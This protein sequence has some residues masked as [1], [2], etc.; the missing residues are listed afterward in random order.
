LNVVISVG[1]NDLRFIKID[2]S[3]TSTP[4]ATNLTAITQYTS[5]T[6]STL[7]RL[8]V[9]PM[10]KRSALIYYATS[11]STLKAQLVTLNI[12]NSLTIS[13]QYTI[14]TS[15]Y[16]NGYGKYCV[17]SISPNRHHLVMLHSSSTGTRTD[18]TRISI[19][20]YDNDNIYG[21]A[22]ESAAPGATFSCYTGSTLP[23][24]IATTV[25]QIV[26]EDSNGDLTVSEVTEKQRFICIKPG[27][28]R[29]L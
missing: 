29:R 19:D 13:S 20:A 9:A 22:A 14:T 28:V 7:Q 15:L 1:D 17:P 11:P 26:Y 27:I 6:G 3:S 24:S 5:N 25:G 21:I 23:L 2:R 18:Y 16:S 12:D 10:G 8:Q 4:T